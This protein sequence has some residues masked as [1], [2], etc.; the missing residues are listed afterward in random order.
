[1]AWP[2]VDNVPHTLHYTARTNEYIQIYAYV[3][4]VHLCGFKAV[5]VA[6]STLY[7]SL[8]IICCTQMIPG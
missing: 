8:S 3:E 4:L 1:M 2:E 5:S 6:V 7:T